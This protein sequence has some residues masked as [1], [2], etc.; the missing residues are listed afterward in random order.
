LALLLVT[1]SASDI[2]AV[3]GEASN[4]VCRDHVIN[5]VLDEA[6]TPITPAM[7]EKARRRC[8]VARQ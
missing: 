5:T 6:D 7:H 1:R 8:G 4:Q 2:N 3:T